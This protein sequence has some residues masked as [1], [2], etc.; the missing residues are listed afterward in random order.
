MAFVL[1]PEAVEGALALGEG[2]E[3]FAPEI[4]AEGEQEEQAVEAE[5]EEHARGLKDRESDP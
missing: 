1:A 3:T 2:A 4:E 5:Y